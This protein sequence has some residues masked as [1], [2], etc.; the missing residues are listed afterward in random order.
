MYTVFGV[1][2]FFLPALDSLQAEEAIFN[3]IISSHTGIENICEG[4][5]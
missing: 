2:T 3:Y 5:I 1:S 4:E